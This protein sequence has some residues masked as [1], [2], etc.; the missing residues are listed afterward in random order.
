MSIK[1]HDN[2]YLQAGKHIDD[3][4]F[5]ENNQRYAS[6]EAVYTRI[7]KAER[8]LDGVHCVSV[9][10]DD[11]ET[12]VE[13][14]FHTNTDTLEVKTGQPIDMFIASSLT[15]GTAVDGFLLVWDG[16]TGRLAKM[17]GIVA[18]AIGQMVINTTGV[19][20]TVTS[21][22]VGIE[23]EANGAG[24]FAYSAK[25][26]NVP[27]QLCNMST[28]PTGKRIGSVTRANS[29]GIT[30]ENGF[31]LTRNVRIPVL[32]W[33]DPVLSETNGFRESI[34]VTDNTQ[35]AECTQWEL[36]LLKNGLLTKVAWIDHEG[37]FVTIGGGGQNIYD[38]ILPNA[39][40]VQSR[41]DGVLKLPV[42]WTIAAD[43]V[44]DH[45]LLVTHGL[46]RN[47]VSV[48]V[49]RVDAFGER[50]LYGNL[51]YSGIT[52]PTTSTLLIQGLATSETQIIIHI[53]FS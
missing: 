23:A 49:F 47:I 18:N 34:V 43:S 38:I 28:T 3:K 5:N 8:V 39:A 24:T 15:V 21:D 16:I 41:C 13:Y 20:L 53:T 17:A 19:G 27:I 12:G 9:T 40:S 25:S 11:V 50:F 1:Q 42:G 29:A 31:A 14:W 10:V 33:T 37:N 52:A 30:V 26:D 44:N 6:V 22:Y 32:G 45:D 48:T 51:A 2:T 4:Y 7:R 46:G 36:E 35:A